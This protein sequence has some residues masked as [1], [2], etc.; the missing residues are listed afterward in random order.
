VLK[1]RDILVRIWIR[2]FVPQVLLLYFFSEVHLNQ[3]T[4]IK[5]H[6]EVTK[7]SR[8]QG[9]SYFFSFFFLD[10]RKIRIRIR[11][12]YDVFIREAQKLTDRDPQYCFFYFLLGLVVPAGGGGDLWQ[13]LQEGDRLPRHPRHLPEGQ[14]YLLQGKSAWDGFCD[15]SI[16]CKV[17]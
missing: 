9:F 3:S 2:G 15:H 7:N 6:K 14:Y 17:E 4:K 13:E 16:F 5:C 10:N 1:I 12:N 8:N 11:T